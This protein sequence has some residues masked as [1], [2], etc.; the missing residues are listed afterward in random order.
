[1]CSA[2]KY[3]LLCSSHYGLLLTVS[4]AH[5]ATETVHTS[6]SAAHVKVACTHITLNTHADLL[7]LLCCCLLLQ[8]S[9]L[10]T[11]CLLVPT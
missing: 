7:L 6:V 2:T 11:L 9:L 5:T 8:W 1:M 4:Q 3:C 10:A